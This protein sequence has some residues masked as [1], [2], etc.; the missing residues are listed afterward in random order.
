MAQRVFTQPFCVAGAIIEKNGKILLVKE[1]GEK[2]ADAG[3]WNQPGGWIDVGEDP[4]VAVKREV[5]EETGYEF[6]P[7]HIVGIYSLVRDDLT[8]IYGGDTPHAIKII[9]T[10]TL[11][12]KPVRELE[13]DVSSVEGFTQDQIEKMGAALRDVDIIQEV[14]DYYA[15]Q[16]FPLDI[17]NHTIQK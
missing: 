6:T 4:L 10:G 11:S 15:G 7:T 13:S 16:R 17:I 2:R 8:Q 12:D 3:K 14:K 5:A 1:S 9:Y